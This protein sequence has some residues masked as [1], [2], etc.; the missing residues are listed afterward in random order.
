M[1]AYHD[2]WRTL[3][4]G[5][6]AANL[7]AP[8]VEIFLH[9]PKTGGSSIT[10]AAE[11]TPSIRCMNLP[12]SWVAPTMCECG[13]PGCRDAE[14][15][16]RIIW[17]RTETR[18]VDRLIV[19]FG[20]EPWT[21]IDWYRRVTE[22]GQP[23]SRI[24]L[25]ARPA[26]RRIESMFADYWTQ[27]GVAED[28]MPSDRPLTAH[29]G[30][31]LTQYRNDAVHYRRSDG[32][33]DGRAWFRAFA[34]H[35]GGVPFFL[36]EVFDGSLDRFRSELDSGVLQLVRTSDVG[37]FVTE[38]TGDEASEPVRRSRSDLD[39]AIAPALAE[40]SDLIDD[41][42]RRDAAF[43]TVIAERLADETFL[44]R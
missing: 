28:R 32:S 36:T 21:V 19:R 3:I 33:I 10:K 12:A 39:P 4:P 18:Q 23:V 25:G 31:L 34:E 42:A 1:T 27:V 6:V 37:R 2:T 44:P 9:L 11:T 22:G 17:W 7:A 30:R 26:R 41:L 20:H 24:L 13:G 14:R 35:G 29:R 15:R 5:V 38:L 8:R 16:R 43:D 40:A